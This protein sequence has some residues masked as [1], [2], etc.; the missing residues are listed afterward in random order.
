[1]KNKFYPVYLGS[2][3]NGSDNQQSRTRSLSRGAGSPVRGTGGIERVC[4]KRFLTAKGAENRQNTRSLKRF[5][6]TTWRSLYF[7]LSHFAVNFFRLLRQPLIR[8]KLKGLIGFY[9]FYCFQGNFPVHCRSGINPAEIDSAFILFS[10]PDNRPFSR[11]MIAVYKYFYF[12]S[13]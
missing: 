3:Q 1:L 12:I 10:I 8:I 7:L 11:C 4:L 9:H 6:I 2:I 5:Y 13:Q